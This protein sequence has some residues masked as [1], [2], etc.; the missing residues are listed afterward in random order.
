[1]KCSIKGCNDKPLFFV[2]ID[3]NVEAYCKNHFSIIKIIGED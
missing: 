3:G 2:R 1:M